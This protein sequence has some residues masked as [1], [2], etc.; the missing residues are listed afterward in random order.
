MKTLL[1]NN[2]YNGKF[3][4]LN[5]YGK[6]QEGYK[7]FYGLMKSR[8]ICCLYSQFCTWSDIIGQK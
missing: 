8:E 1:S 4:I 2:N 7:T 5:W 3:N 6:Y